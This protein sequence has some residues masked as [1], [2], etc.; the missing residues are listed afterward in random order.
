MHGI[1]FISSYVLICFS[2]YFFL[3]LLLILLLL[4]IFCLLLC[5]YQVFDSSETYR[6]FNCIDI[7]AM[8]FIECCEST[9]PQIANGKLPVDMKIPKKIRAYAKFVFVTHFFFIL[10]FFPIVN[11]Q[12]TRFEQLRKGWILKNRVTQLSRTAFI[13]HQ[14]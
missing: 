4:C 7:I 3:S 14:I 2:L 8:H 9:I 6:Y 13:F 11:K 5:T 12:M 10:R 1:N